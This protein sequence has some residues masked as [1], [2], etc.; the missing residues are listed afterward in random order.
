[1]AQMIGAE[2]PPPP[3]GAAILSGIAAEVTEIAGAGEIEMTSRQ[4]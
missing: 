1:M 3:D 4:I 2:D